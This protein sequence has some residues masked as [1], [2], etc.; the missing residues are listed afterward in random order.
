[1]I[2]SI[3]IGPPIHVHIPG[4]PVEKNIQP[5]IEPRTGSSVTLIEI[6]NGDTYFRQ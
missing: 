3:K 4:T 1:M 5:M 6:N 2:P